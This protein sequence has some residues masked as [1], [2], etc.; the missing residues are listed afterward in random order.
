MVAVGSKTLEDFQVLDPKHLGD[1]TYL[2][3]TEENRVLKAKELHANRCLSALTFL[4]RTRY[5]QVLG[6][7]RSF[8]DRG[9]ITEREL[10]EV[11]SLPKDSPK[12]LT[13]ASKAG[14]F[15]KPLSTV[16]EDHEMGDD[17]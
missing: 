1:P 14:A 17:G 10:A 11:M 5:H 16:Q 4:H 3:Y 7:G 2:S 9:W 8:V 12:D 6:V 13:V 15:F